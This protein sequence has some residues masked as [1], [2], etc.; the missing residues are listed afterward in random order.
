MDQRAKGGAARCLPAAVSAQKLRAQIIGLLAP[1]E[2]KA[3]VT[4]VQPVAEMTLEEALAE[5]EALDDVM[6]TAR[7]QLPRASA[8]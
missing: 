7:R 3:T 5:L 2:V 8:E 1:L 6:R 4:P